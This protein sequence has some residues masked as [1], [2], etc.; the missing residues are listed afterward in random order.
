MKDNPYKEEILSENKIIRIFKENTD[1][2]EYIWHRDH[3]DRIV[4]A[5]GET[6]WKIQIDNE[7]P[8]K[9]EKVFIPKN[10]Y[11]RVI[12]GTEDLKIKITK[13]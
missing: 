7:I 11:H 1:S 4:E 2:E 8:K 10:I 9:L 12:K 6:D 3:E 13:L 5:I